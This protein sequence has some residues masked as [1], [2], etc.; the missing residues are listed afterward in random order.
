MKAQRIGAALM[1][2]LVSSC[3]SGRAQTSLGGELKQTI[4]DIANLRNISTQFLQHGGRWFPQPQGDDAE[5]ANG[6]RDL[7]DKVGTF[8]RDLDNGENMETLK[9]DMK[10]V[11]AAQDNVDAVVPKINGSREVMM[12]LQ[13]V[14]TDLDRVRTAFDAMLQ[15]YQGGPTNAKEHIPTVEELTKQLT[16]EVQQFKASLGQFL[17]MPS[18]IPPPH[19][20][21]L[22]LVQSLKQFQELL[23]RFIQ[24]HENNRPLPHLQEQVK[25]I[26]YTA[27]KMDPFADAIGAD[28][29]TM[30]KWHLVRDTVDSLH[31]LIGNAPENS[32]SVYLEADPSQGIGGAT[33]PRFAPREH[34]LTNPGQ[35]AAVPEGN[36]PG[37]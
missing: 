11:N 4:A 24:E 36:M 15:N 37:F 2:F 17:N 25:Q 26:R 32:D 31:V 19:E 34:P 22:L 1:I 20:E 33:Q 13:K 16:F 18:R 21:D 29:N 12:D 14:D 9:F 10:Q 30:Q 5:A 6:M 35:G 8:K 28:E 27:R 3:A 7:F 23:A